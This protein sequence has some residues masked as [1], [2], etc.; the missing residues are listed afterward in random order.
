MILP[1]TQERLVTSPEF[2]TIGLT[3]QFSPQD[4]DFKSGEKHCVFL[5]RQFN[6][7]IYWIY[8]S[9]LM[10]KLWKLD[11]SKLIVAQ[12]EH[13]NAASDQWLKKH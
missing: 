12:S 2:R 8:Y 10:Y 1:E 11:F 7:W 5:K 13:Y 4:T 6:T 3:S 9:C